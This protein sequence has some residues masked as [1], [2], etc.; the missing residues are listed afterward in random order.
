M[1]YLFHAIFTIKCFIDISSFSPHYKYYE[2]VLTP[3]FWTRALRLKELGNIL[4]MN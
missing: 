2:I 4:N 3:T 1:K